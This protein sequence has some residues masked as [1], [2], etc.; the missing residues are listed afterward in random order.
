ML[1]FARVVQAGSFSGAARELGMPKSTVSRRV[2]DLEERIGAR[3]LQRT[4]R[5]LGLTDAGRV[6]YDYAARIVSDVEEAEQAVTRLQ[7]S[8]RGL[9]RVSAP[10]SFAVFGPAFASFLSGNP[11]VQLEL[12]CTDRPVDLVEERFDLA[13][14]AGNLA[15]SSLIARR[16]GV[17]R[18]ILVAA[19]DYLSRRKAPRAPAGLVKHDCVAFAAGGAAPGLWTLVPDPGGEAPVERRSERGEKVEVRVTPRFEV[20]DPELARNATREGAGIAFLPEFVCVEDVRSG[21][22]VRVLPGWCSPPAPL[23]AVYPSSRH[24][25]PKVAAFVEHLRRTFRIGETG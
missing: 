2:S 14:R 16:L 24:L 1:V 23:Q 5:K 22:L 4:T 13:I 7:A 12:Y 25:S 3:L 19:P 17:I 11:D 21:R 18:R 6:F 10:L 9:L 20:N 15:D 8:P